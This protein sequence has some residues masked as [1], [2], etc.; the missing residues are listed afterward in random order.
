MRY[1]VLAAYLVAAVI[2]TL[3]GPTFVD[4]ARQLVSGKQIKNGSVTGKDIK[5]RSLSA[6]HL[7]AGTIPDPQPKP[8]YDRVLLPLK[9]VSGGSTSFERLTCP[10]GG[11]AINGG[12][13]PSGNVTF[14]DHPASDS[15][16]DWIVIVHSTDPV[17]VYEPY[18]V[19]AR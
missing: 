9:T 13:D 19:C 5:K 15:A 2:G 12:I 7:R 14:E 8:I 16:T 1:R 11:T 6:S 17:Y 10:N 4:A 18:V 3:T